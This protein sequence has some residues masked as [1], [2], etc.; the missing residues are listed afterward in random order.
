MRNDMVKIRPESYESIGNQKEDSMERIILGDNQFF[1]I[2]HMSEELAR[3]QS[4]RFQT[5]EAVM[6][7][8]DAA[9]DEGI[10]AFM[11]TTHG[12]IAAICRH[13]RT[14]A[15]RYRN[16]VFYPCMPY[17]HKYADAV[18]QYGMVGALKHFTPRGSVL[19]SAIQGGIAVAR[20]DIETLIKLLVDA[21]MAMFEGVPTPVIFMQNVLTDLLLGL[22]YYDAFNIFQDHIHKK[23]HAEAGFISMNMP[24]LLY[25]LE[26]AGITNP[27]ICSN[28]NKIGF[29]M[30]GGQSRYEELIEKS[31]FR[32]IA[33]SIFASGSIKPH[34]AIEY[35]TGLGGIEGFVFGAS[36]RKNI[37][38]T[39]QLLSRNHHLSA[40]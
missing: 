17:A 23:Y 11:C 25:A 40:S 8:L 31:V 37:R 14:N 15:D 13:V 16:L 29:R 6:G 7:V 21:E 3:Q 20:T 27:I 2:N 39:V 30:S 22:R 32:P 26:T 18:T 36:T 1:G 34:E 33:M 5:D 4:I 12:R 19:S 9:Y 10:R 38:D 35:V 24:R 28:I